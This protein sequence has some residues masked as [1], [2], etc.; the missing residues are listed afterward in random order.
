MG[1][2]D[3]HLVMA[4]VAFAG[5]RTRHQLGL[6]SRRLKLDYLAQLDASMEKIVATIISSSSRAPAPAAE[7]P[8]TL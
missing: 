4:V 5:A 8:P 3:V 7:C 2:V 6:R 1:D